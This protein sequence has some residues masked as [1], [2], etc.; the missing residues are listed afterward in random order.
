MDCDSRLCL[1][2]DSSECTRQCCTI[3]KTM[4]FKG[5]M[6]ESVTYY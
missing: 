6:S 5:S 3:G 2:L 1:K 4:A